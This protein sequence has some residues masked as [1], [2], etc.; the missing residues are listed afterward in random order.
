MSKIIHV[1]IGSTMS[2]PGDVSGNLHQIKDFALMAKRDGADLLLT[3]EMS[4]TGY[5]GYP[6]VVATAERAGEGPV[7]KALAGYA[8]D[9]G[10]VICAG[11]VEADGDK[12]YLAHYIIY[13]NGQ[14][15][16]QRKHRVT[17][18]DRPLD[19]PVELAPESDGDTLGQPVDPQFNYFKVKNVKCG[20]VICA[21]T[22]IPNLSEKFAADGVDLMLVPT[23][24]G[25]KR[26]ECFTDA[27]LA[28]EEGREGYL[29]ILGKQLFFPG[30]GITDCIKYGRGLAAVNMCGFDG[31]ELYHRGHGMIINAVGEVAGF[32][33]GL[34]NLDRQRP[35]YAHATI[36]LSDK[37][38]VVD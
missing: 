11:F 6:E 31:H 27:E 14:Y 32:F 5:G 19:A 26:E 4:V 23:G 20:L 28:T 13:P 9:S 10:A 17:R 25:G 21:D 15:L 18:T 24:G 30:K 1:A 34:P 35:M 29:R 37:I 16:V 3:P 7:Y 2:K 38:K 12:R 36:D 22:G 33:H 8:A